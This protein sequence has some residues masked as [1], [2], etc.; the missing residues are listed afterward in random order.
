MDSSEHPEASA[1]SSSESETDQDGIISVMYELFVFFAGS[2]NS[3][4]SL[5]QT[6]CMNSICKTL[7]GF[8]CSYSPLYHFLAFEKSAAKDPS[9]L[10]FTL[11][12]SLE[13]ISFFGFPG[14][15]QA[16]FCRLGPRSIWQMPESEV[17][18]WNVKMVTVFVW[19]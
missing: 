12:L 3:M 18:V 2:M 6:L 8:S 13:P 9:L 10:F 19:N 1:S 7:N 11:N 16:W 15:C 4:F 5:C 17:F 14:F